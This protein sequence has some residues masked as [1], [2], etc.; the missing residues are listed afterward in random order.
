MN[1][2]YYLYCFGYSLLGLIFSMLMQMKSLNDKAKA[3]NVIFKPRS[4]FQNEWT[5]ILLSLT[6]IGIALFSIPLVFELE[7]KYIIWIKPLFLPVGYTGT[8]FMLKVFGIWNKKI[9]NAIDFKTTEADKA[10]GN[11][12]A[13]TPAT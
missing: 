5:S 6:V 3:A 11:L 1:I 2:Y 4:F 12:N 7:P 10:S 13:P 9:N 8:D